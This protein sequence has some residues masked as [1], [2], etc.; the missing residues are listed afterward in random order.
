MFLITEVT[1]ALIFPM[2]LVS[3]AIE[4]FR[5]SFPK[6]VEPGLVPSLLSNV[7]DKESVYLPHYNE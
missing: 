4:A 3:L 7:Q 2:K 6:Q 5:V 1:I